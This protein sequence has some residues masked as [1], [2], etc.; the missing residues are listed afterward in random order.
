MKSF[1]RRLLSFALVFV[2]F[3]SILPSA[4][5]ASYEVPA[6]GDKAWFYIRTHLERSDNGDRY[7]LGRKDNH[8]LRR[9][10]FRPAG[11]GGTKNYDPNTIMYC[12]EFGTS[13]PEKPHY[14][15][16]YAS[17]HNY[18]TNLSDTAKTGILLSIGYGFPHSSISTLNAATEDD[19]IAATQI[20]VWEF[21]TGYRTSFEGMPSNTEFYNA[22]I[23]STPAYNAYWNI[24]SMANKYYKDSRFDLDY[25]SNNDRFII[26]TCGSAQTMMSFTIPNDVMVNNGVLA[27]PPQFSPDGRI[28]IYKKDTSGNPLSGAGFTAKNQST[29]KVFVIGP[30]N[31]K[32]YAISDL[33]PYGAYTVTE[34]NFPSGYEA[35]GESSWTVTLNNSTP[36]GIAT[37][38]VVNKLQNGSIK[39]TK[40]TNTGTH[41]DGWQFTVWRINN[42]SSWTGIGTYTTDANG[43]VTVPGLSPGTYRVRETGGKYTSEYWNCPVTDQNV[44]VEAGKTSSVAFTNNHYGKLKI[45]KQTNTGENLEG[46]TF[47]V[48]DAYWNHIGDYT[49]GADGTV[50]IDKL[51]P[52]YDAV[53]SSG[54][55]RVREIG[56]PGWNNEYWSNDGGTYIVNV[57]AGATVTHTV[58]NNHYGK[59]K[60]NKTT[61]TG[62]NLDGWEIKVYSDSA[63]TKLVGAYTTG[64]DGTVISDKLTPGTYYAKETAKDTTY[65][66]SDSS[67]KTITVSAGQ[68]ATASFTNTHHGKVKISKELATDGS[69]AGWKF[70][71]TRISDNADM[72]ILTSGADGTVISDK[73]LPGKYRIEEIFEEN[74]LF[75]CKTEN[76]LTVTIKEGETAEVSFTNA[77]RPGNIEIEK[78]N[79]AGKYLADAK[80]L[81]EWSEDG[82]TWQAVTFSDKEDVIK[83]ACGSVALTDGTLTTDETGKIVFENLYPG[84]QYRVTELEAPEGYVKLVDYAFTGELPVEDLTVSLKVINSRGYVLPET[85]ATD[86]GISTVVG[87]AVAILA[88]SMI[89]ILVFVSLKPIYNG[90]KRR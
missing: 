10:V 33:L 38:N 56:G 25:L 64:A 72:G 6:E 9:Y 14:T 65:W 5:A 70:Q 51:T 54:A 47:R 7:Y 78:V 28:E 39:I 57:T 83:G 34:T 15:A 88:L 24:L 49:T 4:Q 71:V 20:L 75:Y 13:L 41:L 26:W 55:Y 17:N 27:G 58:T 32:G 84:L 45:V 74:S 40:T 89:M 60:F 86:T 30:T 59:I 68:T 63:C 11:Y 23:K 43:T 37:L 12:V 16:G 69:L 53:T 85:G 44:T 48:W 3:I 90:K 36:N 81:L 29:G 22:Y 62:E 21:Y 80:F 1:C 18:W 31:N 77:L 82:Q 52:H 73:L 50:T 8:A 66:T 46:W 67:I 35:A 61:N 2:M 42:A 19:A 87:T 79:V 76:P